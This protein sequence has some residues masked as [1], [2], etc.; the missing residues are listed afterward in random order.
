M[1][2]YID[3]VKIYCFLY[4][5]LITC[6]CTGLRELYYCFAMKKILI[7]IEGMRLIKSTNYIIIPS[8]MQQN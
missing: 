4:N 8:K 2:I 6:S 5:F 1:A 7:M 3:K